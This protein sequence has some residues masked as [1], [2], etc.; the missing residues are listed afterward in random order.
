MPL[1]EVA[2]VKAAGSILH[3]N[4]DGRISALIDRSL[5]VITAL[6]GEKLGLAERVE[7]HNGDGPIFLTALP[8]TTVSEVMDL[9]NNTAVQTVVTDA[10]TGIVWHSKWG[11]IFPRG[12]Q[13]WRVTYTG[14]ADELPGD[15]KAAAIEIVLANLRV[16]EGLTMEKDGDWQAQRSPGMADQMNVP[17]AARQ[18]LT[19]RRLHL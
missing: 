7:T 18:I 8:I 5:E 12:P 15:L 2:D 13:R 11:Q 4:D 16:G 19:K 1:L 17:P 10:P 14:G 6:T 9:S 3:A